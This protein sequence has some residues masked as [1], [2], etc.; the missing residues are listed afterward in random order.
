MITHKPICYNT[1]MSMF[2]PW[3]DLD[4]LSTEHMRATLFPNHPNV[5]A[6]ISRDDNSI[7]LQIFNLSDNE[8]TRTCFH[9]LF[10]RYDTDHAWVPDEEFNA[11]PL[12]NYI[13][14]SMTMRFLAD[15]LG[16]AC[17]MQFVPQAGIA[18]EYGILFTELAPTGFTDWFPST[19]SENA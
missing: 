2:I 19:E 8:Q 14:T 11:A 13:P 5:E 12:S 10:N 6:E 7:N 16:Y 9:N 1:G 18:T 4:K 3:N 17:H 15:L